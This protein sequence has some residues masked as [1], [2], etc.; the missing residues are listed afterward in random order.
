MTWFETIAGN[1]RTCS[2]AS[3]RSSEMWLGA[4][5]MHLSSVGS[6]PTSS[7]AFLAVSMI[8]WMICG[9]ASWMITPSAT[10]PATAR[11]FGP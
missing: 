9:S 5:T 11:A 4:P 8:H 2:R 10:R 7:A 3:A 6:R 1:Q